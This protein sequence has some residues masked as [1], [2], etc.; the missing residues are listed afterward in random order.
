MCIDYHSLNHLTKLDV[1]PIPRIAD[2]F[3]HL[4]KA[5]VF[6]SINLS[7]AYHQI[8]ICEGDEHK[9]A[10]LTPQGLYKYV[11]IPI[12]LT[13]APAMFQHVMSLL[14]SYLMQCMIIYLDGI[15]VFSPTRE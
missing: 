5:T 13:N 3:D 9:T 7:H 10:F 11:V 2:L 8:C 12:G 1:F 6:S 14:F 15:L 4:G